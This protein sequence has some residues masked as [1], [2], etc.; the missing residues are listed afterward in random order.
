MT[1]KWSKE[2]LIYYV[3]DLIKNLDGEEFILEEYRRNNR[4]EI[5][6]EEVV[7]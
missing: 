3:T 5:E 6:I 4:L 7:E 2:S 1:E